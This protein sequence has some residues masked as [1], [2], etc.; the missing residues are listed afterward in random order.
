MKRL[1]VH[2]Q[3]ELH[4][5]NSA[6]PDFP[7]NLKDLVTLKH[8]AKVQRARAGQS[9]LEIDDV[10]PND[11]IQLELD[12]GLKL[13]VRVDDLEKDFG[14]T[15][16]RG[17]DG[18]VVELPSVLPIGASSRGIVGN[19]VIKGFKVF[20]LD[21]VGATT[22]LIKDKVEGVLKPGPGLY[23][24]EGKEASDYTRIKS[25]EKER[26][27]KPWLVFIHG[28]ASSSTEG[29]F[30]G[31]WDGGRHA[32]MVQ[33]LAHY[34]KRV[35]AFQHRTLSHNP[36][37]NALELAGYFP[38]GA[39]LQLV[40]R[41]RGGLVGEL[42]CRSMME[43]RFPFDQDDLPIFAQPDRKDDLR[44]LEQLGHLLQQKQL[45]IER[46]VRVGM[47]SPRHHVGQWPVGSV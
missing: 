25:L 26:T 2:G 9:P 19:W 16:S 39:R 43:G 4:D 7:A 8:S 42:L 32:R 10:S 3:R 22:D 28:T 6:T 33:L 5:S 35:L 30:G 41:F 38:K 47:S 27:D 17:L 11:L 20:G 14:L 18:D 36:I 12:Q 40:W 45:I 29:S 31:L 13:W 1:I 44:Q 24:W 23:R 15:P 34:P 37:Q 21:P 46:F